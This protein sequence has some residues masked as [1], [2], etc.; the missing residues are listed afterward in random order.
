M[1]PDNIS[2]AVLSR[3][4]DSGTAYSILSIDIADVDVGRNIGEVLNR[5]QANEFAGD[6]YLISDFSGE[7]FSHSA[8][9]IIY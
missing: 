7:F 9:E 5:S 1:T 8:N 3:G 6:F 2:K 4:L